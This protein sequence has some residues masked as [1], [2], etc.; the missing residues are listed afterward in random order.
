MHARVSCGQGPPAVPSS[1]ARRTSVHRPA[2]RRGP[3][4][5]RQRDASSAGRG[6]RRLQVK[7]S[8]RGDHTRTHAP[9]VSVT[10]N[11]G[12]S[13]LFRFFPR[14]GVPLAPTHART[15]TRTHTNTHTHAHT[16]ARTQRAGGHAHAQGR[17][18]HLQR[19]ASEQSAQGEVAEGRAG[20]VRAVVLFSGCLQPFGCNPAVL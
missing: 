4:A 2:G 11:L 10:P 12:V 6:G 9:G 7:I 19:A 15:H 16:H 14:R 17:T 13:L 1:P 8:T 5:R 18:H 3:R 20:A